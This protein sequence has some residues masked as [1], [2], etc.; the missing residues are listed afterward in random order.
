MT[1]IFN[2]KVQSFRQNLCNFWTFRRPLVL[3]TELLC[4]LASVLLQPQWKEGSMLSMLSMCSAFESFWKSAFQFHGKPLSWR[5]VW[6]QMNCWIH[7]LH[8]SIFQGHFRNFKMESSLTSFN[9]FPHFLLSWLS[10]YFTF[11]ICSFTFPTSVHWI[12]FIFLT[13]RLHTFSCHSDQQWVV[14]VL[15]SEVYRLTSHCLWWWCNLELFPWI[16]IE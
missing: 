2:Q 8:F 14:H 10:I 13:V 4:L 12:A 1:W 6:M 15:G 9:I 7:F 5:N 16:Y 11:I 3:S